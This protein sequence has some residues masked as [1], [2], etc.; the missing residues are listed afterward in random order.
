MDPCCG[1]SLI[2]QDLLITQLSLVIDI[3]E[4]FMFCGMSCFYLHDTNF[5]SY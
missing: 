4:H 2:L 5:N 1:H 3:N